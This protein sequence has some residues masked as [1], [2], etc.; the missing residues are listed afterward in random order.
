MVRNAQHPSVLP[1]ADL[2]Q[3]SL[4][5]SIVYPGDAGYDDNRRVLNGLIDRY[6]AAIVQPSGVAD[7][8]EVVNYA[9]DHDVLLSVRAGGHNIAGRA[10]NDGGIVLDLRSM[11]AVSVDPVARTVWVQGGAT[12]ADLDRETQL[13]GLAAPGGVVSTTGIGGLTLHGGVG[14]LRRTFGLSIDNLLR[15]E[16]VTADGTV[17]RAGADTDSDLF[18]AV[19]GAGSNFGVVTGFEFRLHPVGPEVELIATMYALEDGE[20]VLRG[21]REFIAGMPDVVNSIALSWSVPDADPFPPDVRGRPIVLISAVYAGPPEDG[22]RLLQPLRELAEPVLDIS[23]TERYVN[24]Q[25]SFDPFFPEG[26]NYYWK[27]RYV[28][29]LTDRAIDII[30]DIARSRPSPHS[31][32]LI[33]HLGGAFA[34]VADEDTAFGRRSAPFLVNVEASWDDP[35]DT[36]RNI[37]W[38]RDGIDRLEPF[39][40]G[41]QY[42]NFP[43]LGEEKDAQ[44]RDAYGAKYERLTQLKARYDPG[45]LFRSNLNIVP[46]G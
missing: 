38:T 43:G 44:L 4:K 25:A 35:A 40:H 8:V 27:S 46:A 20:R 10:V 29:A 42:L 12:W 36:E 1:E 19:Q 6:P 3:N 17:H 41:G 22:R 28:D 11:R 26:R 31:D 21:W 33:W 39:S 2:L 5:G 37:A 18:W 13:Y 32:L 7:V 45:N 34:R 15:V 9:R 14:H 23:H 24:V 30:V 16:I